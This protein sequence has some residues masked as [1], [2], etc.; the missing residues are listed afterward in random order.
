MIQKKVEKLLAK[1][2]G[3]PILGWTSLRLIKGGERRRKERQRETEQEGL[4][5]QR[6]DNGSIDSNAA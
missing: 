1:A 3:C 5:V 6:Q 4:K 2:K